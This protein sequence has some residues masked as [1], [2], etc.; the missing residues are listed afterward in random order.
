M[1][2]KLLSYVGILV[3]VLFFTGSIAAG[4]FLIS[5]QVEEHTV[6]T[7]RILTKLI[8]SAILIHLLLL[9]F[10]GFPLK[11]TLFAIV[12]NVIYLQNL[13]RFPHILLSSKTFIASVCCVVC[14]HL[15]WYNYLTDPDIP[16]YIIYNCN[17]L[18]TDRTRP[19]IAQ[20]ASFLIL[21]VWL[22]PLSLFLCLSAGDM[23]LPTTMNDNSAKSH[24]SEGLAK[25]FVKQLHSWVVKGCPLVGL[26]Q[27][28]E[29]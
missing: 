20:A 28:D 25:A 26:D 2:L 12:A 17:P 22:I 13:N 11:H 14:N 5:E 3:G 6:L 9:V 7:K 10:E 16:P 27:Y 18:Y 15:L 1:I 29:Y 23:V 24:R 8:Y 21:C 19:S 4:L